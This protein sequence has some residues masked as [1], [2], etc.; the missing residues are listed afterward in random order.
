M[1]FWHLK[2]WKILFSTRSN[3]HNGINK[4]LFYNEILQRQ[5]RVIKKPAS[6]LHY[7]EL[8]KIV[9][10]ILRSIK[11]SHSNST[12]QHDNFTARARVT[13]DYTKMVLTNINIHE[14]SGFFFPDW[15][16][17]KRNF[18]KR[19]KWTIFI[20]SIFFIVFSKRVHTHSDAQK[21]SSFGGSFAPIC[22][23]CAIKFIYRLWFFFL[24][25]S[26]RLK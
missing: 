19:Y 13:R 16:F 14:A 6:P 2:W 7:S 23:R 4:F 5:L 21:K 22:I 20:L 25:F 17:L 1:G 26:R 15:V 3:V 10:F 12:I 8:P 11:H 18:T 9:E 24:W